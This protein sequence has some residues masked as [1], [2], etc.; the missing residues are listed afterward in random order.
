MLDDDVVVI[1][2][3]GYWIIE[4]TKHVRT[5]S[6]K[7]KWQELLAQSGLK[8]TSQTFTNYSELQSPSKFRRGLDQLE[9]QMREVVLSDLITTC[10]KLVQ[11]HNFTRC[12]KT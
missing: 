12:V 2:P 1:V 6:S 4:S 9:P 8:N 11:S 10:S 7:F 5:R 3:P